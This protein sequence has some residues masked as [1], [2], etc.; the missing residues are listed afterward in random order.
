MSRDG[1][2][3]ELM[4]L[5]FVDFRYGAIDYDQPSEIAPTGH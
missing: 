5:I 3:P 4:H 1:N 2:P